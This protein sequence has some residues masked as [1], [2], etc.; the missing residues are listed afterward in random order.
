MDIHENARTTPRSR[1][2][3]VERLEAGWTAAAVAAAS[4]VDG[5]TVR[6]WR[7]RHR[8]EGTAGLAD[9]FIGSELSAAARWR[10]P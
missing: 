10:A 1:M 8:A 3:M 9:R 4:G 6:K 7:D 5:K 2:L